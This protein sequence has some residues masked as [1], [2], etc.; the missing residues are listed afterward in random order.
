MNKKKILFVHHSGGLGGAPKSMGYIIKNIDKDIN[1][2]IRLAFGNI[3]VKFHPYSL[4]HVVKHL[5]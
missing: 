2:D 5:E 1:P 3:S 4:A